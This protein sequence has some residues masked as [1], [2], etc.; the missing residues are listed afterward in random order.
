HGCNPCGDIETI[1]SRMYVGLTSDQRFLPGELGMGLVEGA[2]ALRGTKTGLVWL[3][4]ML[5]R[6]GLGYNSM[7][8]EMSKPNLR[9]ELEADLKLVS[10]GR[11]DKRSVLRHHIQKYKTV[12]IESVQKAKKWVVVTDV[13][14]TEG[15]MLSDLVCCSL[16]LDE[17]LSPYLGAA[18][19][20]TEEQ[21]QDMEIPLPVRKC[22]H[23]GRDMV[24]K[25]KREGNGKY[26]TCVGYPACKS[27]VWFPDTVLEVSR[28]ESV[29]PT[30]QPAP[31]HM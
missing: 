9:A 16:R 17:A 10:E 19:E 21:Q 3:V 4:Q 24:L 27:A 22:P 7:G 6:I 30:C 1:K 13:G 25:K 26:L 5:T 20:I 29:C 28:D 11:K 14:Q 15:W 18:Q 23:C 8:Y 31:V 12:F 2:Y